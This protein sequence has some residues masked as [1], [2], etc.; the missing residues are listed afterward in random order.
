MKIVSVTQL[1]DQLLTAT[2][3]IGSAQDAIVE[4]AV[5]VFESFDVSADG[6]SPAS[7]DPVESIVSLT[8]RVDA[9]ALL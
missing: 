4:R 1:S 6:L 2:N 9:S 3:E 7:H 5:S 8:E